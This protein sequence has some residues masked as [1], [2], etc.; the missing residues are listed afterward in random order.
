MATELRN[1]S[2]KTKKV[3]S[4]PTG[5]KIVSKETSVEVEEIENG[6]LINKRTEVTYKMKDQGYND[7]MSIQK[8][9]FSTTNPLQMDLEKLKPETLVDKF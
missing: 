1:A 2:F 8:K 5:A 7:Y 3:Q 4:V 6:F 9:Y